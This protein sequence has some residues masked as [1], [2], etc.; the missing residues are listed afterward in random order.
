MD[1]C[2]ATDPVEVLPAALALVSERATAAARTAAK[3][4]ARDEVKAMLRRIIR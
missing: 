3:I 1:K 4:A 2:H